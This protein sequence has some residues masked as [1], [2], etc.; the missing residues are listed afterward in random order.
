MTERELIRKI[1]SETIGMG[2]RCDA[3]YN[4][5][6]KLCER[7]GLLRVIDE[8]LA[9]IGKRTTATHRSERIHH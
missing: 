7:C 9:K 2:C 6:G 8:G 3:W 5:V 4:R 1:R